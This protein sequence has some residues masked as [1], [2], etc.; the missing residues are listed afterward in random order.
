MLV[1]I[2]DFLGLCFL[3]YLNLSLKTLFSFETPLSIHPSTRPNISEESNFHQ[4]RQKHCMSR[5]P[6]RKTLLFQQQARLTE[7]DAL[8]CI[9]SLVSVVTM[10]WEGWSGDQYLIPV[11]GRDF[12]LLRNIKTGCGCNQLVKGGTV[13][14]LK[15]VGA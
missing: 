7:G 6:R 4:H 13:P 14:R 9:H 12:S 2:G 15:M 3:Y 10:P 5:I 11:R 8:I 1:V